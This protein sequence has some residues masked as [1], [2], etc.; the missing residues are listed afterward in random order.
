MQHTPKSSGSIAA[1]LAVVILFAIVTGKLSAQGPAFIKG[2]VQT[3]QGEPLVGVLIHFGSTVPTHVAT[4]NA[5]GEFQVSRAPEVYHFSRNDL[6]PLALV[7]K[8]EAKELTVQMERSSN[9]L[10]IRNCQ[11]PPGKELVGWNNLLQFL[12]TTSD[13]NIEYGRVDIDAV[14]H[15]ITPKRGKVTLELWFG[16]TSIS[17]LPS[18]SAF[19]GS[20]RHFQRHMAGANGLLVGLDSW[21]YSADDRKWRHTAMAGVGGAFYKNATPEEA[22]IFDAILDAP[23]FIPLAIRK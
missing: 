2:V 13:V 3:M 1:R 19:V 21:G 9:P 20:V 10:I 16:P 12:A 14:R 18:D 23:C 22:T 4:T 11:K 17:T 5:K 8:P 6:Q 15:I 7:L